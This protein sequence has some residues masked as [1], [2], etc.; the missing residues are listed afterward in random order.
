M[1]ADVVSKGGNLLLNIGPGPDGTLHEAAYD[2]LRELGEWM[3]V[4]SEAIYE[5][6]A[7]APYAEGKVRLT[8][9]ADGSVYAIYLADEGEEQL[10]AYLSMTE[11]RP[12]GGATV[13]L[14]GAEGSLRWEAAGT[15]F[16]AEVPES[17]RE[18]PPSRYAWVFKISRVA[19]GGGADGGF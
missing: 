2:R 16:I 14:I 13:S 3:D 17:V 6:R 4:N 11:L 8:G 5:T 7:I 15:G 10:P 1:L 9:R 19:D 12:A 18:N